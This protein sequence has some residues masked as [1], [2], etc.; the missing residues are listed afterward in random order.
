MGA[1][2]QSNDKVS[3]K[4]HQN[5][6]T[7]LSGQLIISFKKVR[8]PKSVMKV[9]LGADITDIVFETIEAVIAQHEGASV[10]QIN[11]ELIIKGLELGFL[12]V[13][14]KQYKDITP[15]LRENFEFDAASKKYFI[16]PNTKFQSRIDIRT[17]IRYYVLSYLRRM[18][19]QRHVSSFDEI[20]LNIMP[21]LKNGITP[22]QQTIRSV[23]EEV[24][25]HAG[26][27]GWRLREHGQLELLP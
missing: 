25:E 17:R 2:K 22:K 3:F 11:E 20:V 24:A 26:H 1:V 6:F 7:V 9:D 27:D 4:K 21:L 19:H 12:D 15:L 18:R 10:E 16:R 13:L 23:L 14:S 8:N 5:P